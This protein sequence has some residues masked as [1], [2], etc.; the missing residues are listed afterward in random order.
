MKDKS[1]VTYVIGVCIVLVTLLSISI[2]YASG[3]W[4][5]STISLSRNSTLDGKERTYDYNYYKITITPTK[6]EYGY[7]YTDRVH[8]LIEL[9]RPLYRLGIKYG[10]QTKYSGYTNYYTV[11]TAKTTNIGS[12]GNGKRY[13]EFS[14]WTSQNQGGHGSITGTVRM[15]NY[16]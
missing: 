12:A 2:V 7:V 10:T 4:I 1:I 14:T 8:L 13:Y 15:E 16:E 5:D 11:G 9:K 3:V 6:L